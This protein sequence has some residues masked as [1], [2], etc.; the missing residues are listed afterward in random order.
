MLLRDAARLSMFLAATTAQRIR[1]DTVIRS[2]IRK[3]LELASVDVA[4]IRK[5]A[6]TSE[7]AKSFLPE[8][9]ADLDAIRQ[10]YERVAQRLDA[11]LTYYHKLVVSASK[12]FQSQ[13]RPDLFWQNNGTS[14][15]G[16]VEP[17]LFEDAAQFVRHVRSASSRAPG[18]YAWLTDF[19]EQG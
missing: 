15:S 12:H 16:L 11:S 10:D 3:H 13:I 2:S 5:L 18:S 17:S 14:R 7:E 9:E 4:Q 6:L 1:T 19:L 8:V